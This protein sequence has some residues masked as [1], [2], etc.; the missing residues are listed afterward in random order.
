MET[1]RRDG[2][3][4]NVE[5]AGNMPEVGDNIQIL[6]AK[7]FEKGLSEKDLVVLSGMYVYKYD[8]CIF[9]CFIIFS[10]NCI[11]V[12]VYVIGKET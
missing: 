11:F 7:F 3:V 4:S 2:L 12:C 9:V 5:L 8:I 1:G 6:K 10:S